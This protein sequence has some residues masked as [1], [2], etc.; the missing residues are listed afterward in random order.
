[1]AQVSWMLAALDDLD[2]QT[3]GTTDYAVDLSGGSV[4]AAP[5]VAWPTAFSVGNAVV[6]RYLAGYTISGDS[7]DD[8]PLPASIKNAILLE[9][10]HLYRNRESTTELDLKELPRGVENLLQPYQIRI[11]FA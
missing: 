11:P 8:V 1:M 4:V 2:E 5:N 9:C 10:G 6:V 3:L 7:P